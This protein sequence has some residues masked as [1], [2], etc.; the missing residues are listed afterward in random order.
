MDDDDVDDDGYNRSHIRLK[1]ATGEWMRWKKTINNGKEAYTY[2][3]L[4]RYKNLEENGTNSLTLLTYKF[5]SKTIIIVNI[6]FSPP[7]YRILDAQT[8]R[9]SDWIEKITFVKRKIQ[10]FCSFRK[11][12]M[13]MYTWSTQWPFRYKYTVI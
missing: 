5:S 7:V 11:I 8:M 2:I 4:V 12:T 3:V 6:F 9:K 10:E 13:F 1:M